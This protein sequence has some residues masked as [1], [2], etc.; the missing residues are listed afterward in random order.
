MK[1]DIGLL[2]QDMKKIRERV[3]ETE[4]RISLLEDELP[5]VVK[6]VTTTEKQAA[7]WQQKMDDLEN[8]MPRNNIRIVGMPEKIEGQNPG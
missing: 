7:F 4:S 1:E 2:R 3:T 8:R 5:P 6:Q